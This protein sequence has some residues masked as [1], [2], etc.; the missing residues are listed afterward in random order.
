MLVPA[1]GQQFG[2]WTV[3]FDLGHGDP[4]VIGNL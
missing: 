4:N 3:H 1:A 2:Q